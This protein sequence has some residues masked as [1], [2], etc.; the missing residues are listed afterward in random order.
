VF[1]QICSL[2]VQ[3]LFV[4]VFRAFSINWNVDCIKFMCGM[5]IM[6]LNMTPNKEV[7]IEIESRA[8]HIG[9]VRRI[10]LDNERLIKR[11]KS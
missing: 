4:E 6:Q 2:L 10:K 9:N 5:S 11:I 7:I 8:T 3:V 1:V